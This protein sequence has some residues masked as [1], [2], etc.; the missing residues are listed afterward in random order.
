M[1]RVFFTLAM[2]IAFCTTISAEKVLVDK[3]KDGFRIVQTQRTTHVFMVVGTMN[4]G[5]I[6]LDCWQK[7]GITQYSIVL[8]FYAEYNIEEGSKLLLKFDND[9]ILE[10]YSNSDITHTWTGNAFAQIPISFVG[11]NVTLEQL[12]KI[13]TQNVV[14]L[15]AE[16]FAD[17]LDGKVYGKKFSKTIKKDYDV[18]E[19][20]LQQEVSLYDDF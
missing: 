14:K 20:A 12:K 1:K 2:L 11:Y 5:A 6:S 4:D 9:E 16:T 15:R 3:V 7:E 10:L 18:I 13:M 17:H 19:K 8:Y